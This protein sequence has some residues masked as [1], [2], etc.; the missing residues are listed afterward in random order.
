MMEVGE[1]DVC[2][3]KTALSV[4]ATSINLCLALCLPEPDSAAETDACSRKTG[5][6]NPDGRI[7]LVVLPDRIR[8]PASSPGRIRVRPL[9]S[10]FR[11]IDASLDKCGPIVII[12]ELDLF[13]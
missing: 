1:Q 4:A 2:R 10:V 8:W 7:I 12:F 11:K 9:L 6:A 13:D 3:A 5:L